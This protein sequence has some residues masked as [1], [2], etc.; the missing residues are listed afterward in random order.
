MT[1]YCERRPCSCPHPRWGHVTQHDLA[2]LFEARLLSVAPTKAT[3]TLNESLSLPKS[4]LLLSWCGKEKSRVEA[5]AVPKIT[6][7]SQDTAAQGA[8]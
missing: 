5:E 4:L 8:H 2:A 3:H 6:D 7:A 1:G